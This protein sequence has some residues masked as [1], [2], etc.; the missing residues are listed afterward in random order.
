MGGAAVWAR[1]AFY[2]AGLEL[3]RRPAGQGR[4]TLALVG[5]SHDGLLSG[6]VTAQAQ[7]LLLPGARSGVSPYAGLGVAAQVVRA[8]HSAGYLALT[9]GVEAPEGT[10]SGWYVESGLA[11]GLLLAA[12]MRWRRF[13]PWWP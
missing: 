11:G 10:R 7:F 13:P 6:R 4:F 3:S 2:G 1:R 5:G 9:V 12:G 8:R